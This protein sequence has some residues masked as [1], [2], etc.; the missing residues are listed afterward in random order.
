MDV[1]TKDRASGAIEAPWHSFRSGVASVRRGRQCGSFSTFDMTGGCV[2][3]SCLKVAEP[4]P[5]RS[6]SRSLHQGRRACHRVALKK[7]PKKATS[8][9]IRPVPTICETLQAAA[10]RGHSVIVAGF[11][12]AIATT[13]GTHHFIRKPSSRNSTWCLRRPFRRRGRCTSRLASRNRSTSGRGGRESASKVKA[14]L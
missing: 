8:K 7:P 13:R 9:R 10:M 3:R 4:L 1:R 6:H 11:M 14:L 5:P 12:H 2:L